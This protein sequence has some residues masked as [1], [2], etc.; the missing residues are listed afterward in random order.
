MAAL[1][2]AA[3]LIWVERR[4]LA[5]WQDRYGPNR[6]GPFGLLQVVADAIKIFMKEDW[7]PPFVD[8]PVFIV[9]P[10]I[11]F[12]T[13][14]MSFAVIPVAPGI[15]VSDLNIGLLFFLAMS[16]L[17]VY[18]VVLAG[19]SS[20]NKYSLVGGMRAAAQ[21][22]SYEVFMGLSLMGVVLLAGSFSLGTIVEAQKKVWFVVPQ[23]PGF[24]LFLIAGLAETRR[25]PF[26]LPEAE[27]ELIAGYHSEYS[28]MKFGMFFVGEYMGITLISGMIAV[29]FFGGWLGPVLPG[30]LWFL[31]KTCV[32]IAF[33]VLLRA[34]LPRPRFDQ[35]MS[36]GWKV[37]LPLAL[38]N[39]LLTGAAVVMRR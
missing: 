37:M 34:A 17:G 20:N 29:L 25:I 30:L 15:V 8:T 10:A 5:L 24:V 19:W 13:V 31:I 1:T 26:D 22:L 28:G 6:A 4:L 39:L 36:I 11:I 9:A 12:V 35:L 2:I 7:I 32:F 16:S 14:L 21:M 27:S 3:S 33:F 38:A 18:S 23:F